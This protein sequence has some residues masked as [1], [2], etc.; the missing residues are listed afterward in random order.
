[1]SWTERV[2]VIRPQALAAKQSKA[3]EERLRKAEAE[4]RALTPT[5]AISRWAITYILNTTCPNEHS[6]NESCGSS[7][8]LAGGAATLKQ[9]ELRGRSSRAV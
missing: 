4:V 6:Y 7:F 5:A 1:V 9:P 2:Q 8:S 3:L